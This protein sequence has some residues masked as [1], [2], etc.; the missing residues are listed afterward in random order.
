[1][2]SQKTRKER[3]PSKRKRKIELKVD[4]RWNKI[5][6][7]KRPSDQATGLCDFD[8]ATSVESQAKNWLWL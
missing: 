8:K 5:K 3:F 4:Q 2:L 1:M 6:M 7:E